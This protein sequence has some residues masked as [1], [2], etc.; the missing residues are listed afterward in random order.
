[1]MRKSIRGI[2]YVLAVL[3]ILVSL[4]GCGI[5]STAEIEEAYR[6][7]YQ[8]GYTAAQ[9]EGPQSNSSFYPSTY[10]E[11]YWNGFDVGFTQSYSEFYG[12]YNDEDY[13][14]VPEDLEEWLAEGIGA[15]L[16]Y[17]ADER[18][19]DIIVQGAKD[20]FLDGFELGWE[21]WKEGKITR[22]WGPGNRYQGN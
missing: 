2:I 17:V 12:N 14:G 20:G 5:H 6:R 9:Q 8:E 13:M 10:T 16:T 1:M 15:H 21:T 11:A 19:P 3:S 4:S 7:G 18:T 22:S